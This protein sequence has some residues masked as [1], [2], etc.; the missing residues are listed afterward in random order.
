[1]EKNHYEEFGIPENAT[2]LEIKKAYRK[3]ALKYHPDRNGGNENFDNI[4]KKINSIH[5]ILSDLE[6]RKKY[7][8]ELKNKRELEHTTYANNPIFTSQNKQQSNS[9]SG[10]KA[11]AD[12]TTQSY[13]NH[14]AKRDIHT[15]YPFLQMLLSN[16]L[17][18]GVIIFIILG[19]IYWASEPSRNSEKSTDKNIQNNYTVPNSYNNHTETSE[20]TGEID[21]RASNSKKSTTNLNINNSNQIINPENRT[22]RDSIKSESQER[23]GEIKF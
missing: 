10:Y 8:S 11:N 15:L 14:K 20:K 2:T 17:G 3:L 7:D 19:L 12:K 6:K 22:T 1:M 16:V 18:V 4:F 5:E 13:T 9:K 23:T 21:F